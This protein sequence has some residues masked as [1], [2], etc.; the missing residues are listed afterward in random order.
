MLW[1]IF[2]KA[3]YI[4]DVKMCAFNRKTT[5]LLKANILKSCHTVSLYVVFVLSHQLKKLFFYVSTML[6]LKILHHPQENSYYFIWRSPTPWK[7]QSF[8]PPFQLDISVDHPP[9]V[10]G[11]VPERH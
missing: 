9:G 7:F 5:D 4:S 11:Y 8:S 1:M 3:L 6:T 10:Y 2:H